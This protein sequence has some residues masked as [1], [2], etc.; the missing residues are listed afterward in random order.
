MQKSDMQLRAEA[1]SSSSSST[2]TTLDE[3]T[4]WNLRMVL[5]NLPTT[6]G[7]KVDRIITLRV[8]FIEEVGYEPPQG[9]VMQ[10]VMGDDDDSST[11]KI[12]SSRWQLSEDPNERKD[13]LWI[14]GLFS[15]PLYPFL[16]LRLEFDE[17][18]LPGSL[19]RSTSNRESGSDSDITTAS[20]PDAIAPFT[21]FAQIDH[22]REDGQVVLSSGADLTIKQKETIK[23]DPFGAATVDVFDDVK[24]GKLQIQAITK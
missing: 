14:W 15:E 7:S 16:L 10:V 20:T 23:A 3:Q 6:Q 2:K 1:S 4:T 17:I 11:A 24:V 13:S 5:Q 21:L 18:L 12:I 8:K 19:S 9:Q 22:R